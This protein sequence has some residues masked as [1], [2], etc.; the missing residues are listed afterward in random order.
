MTPTLWDSIDWYLKCPQSWKKSA[1]KGID[2]MLNRRWAPTKAIERGMAFEKAVCEG[3]KNPLDAVADDLNDKFMKAYN[4]I[5]AEGGVF[6]A[7]TKKFIEHDGKEFILYGRKDVAFPDLTIDIKTTG[8]YR[9]ASSYL[10]KWQHKVYAL[11]DRMPNFK[12]IVFEFNE[13]G[14]MIDIHTI[15]YHVDDF[16]ALEKEIMEKLDSVIKFL[17]S[18]KKLL[19]AYLNKFNQYN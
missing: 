8:N 6:Q 4:E 13:F 17:R 16:A 12:Y 1:H 15:E 3:N 18:D 11:C 5:H 7:K 10:A 9:G 2:D 14:M 19:T